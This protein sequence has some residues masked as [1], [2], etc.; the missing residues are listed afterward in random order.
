MV[1]GPMSDGKAIRRG[2]PMRETVA[3]SR[4]PRRPDV[5]LLRQL[6]WIEKPS[7][8][9]CACSDCA[10]VFKPSGPPVGNSLEEM[11]A[12]YKRLRDEEFAIHVCAEHPRA[13]KEKS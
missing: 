9:G 10:W 1:N 6:I 8:Q 2:Q 12:I 3:Y 11:M 5:T 4:L 13:K 7:F